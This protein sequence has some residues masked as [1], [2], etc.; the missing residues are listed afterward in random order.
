MN[1]MVTTMER[2]GE[3]GYKKMEYFNVNK[4]IFLI[5]QELHFT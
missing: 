1:L 2:L 3:I 5:C 4:N